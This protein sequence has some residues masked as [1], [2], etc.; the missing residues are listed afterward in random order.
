MNLIGNFTP[1]VVSQKNLLKKS[2]P[3]LIKEPALASDLQCHPQ[4]EPAA[5]P[6]SS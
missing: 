6:L 4:A 1:N 2:L 5:K 3:T